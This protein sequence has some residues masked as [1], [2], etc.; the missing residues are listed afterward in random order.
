MEPV[1]HPTSDL[2]E[3]RKPYQKPRLETVSLRPKET[4]LGLCRS[5]SIA[6]NALSMSDCRS[7]AVCFQD[8]TP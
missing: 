8:S 6:Q 4:V 1:N 7:V 5:A 2:P 3:E